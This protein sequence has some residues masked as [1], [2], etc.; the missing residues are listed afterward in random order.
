M[1]QN[2]RHAEAAAA[3][4]KTVDR[5]DPDDAPRAAVTLGTLRLES[6]DPAGAQRAFQAAKD[7]GHP[8]YAP[9]GAVLVGIRLMEAGD[10]DRAR[11]AFEQAITSHHP[12]HAPSAWVMKG[13]L[14]EKQANPA[15][16]NAAYRTAI[17]SGNPE[18][19]PLAAVGLGLLL[20]RQGDA[21]G[22]QKAYQTAIDSE[23]P[24]HAPFAMLLTGEYLTGGDLQSRERFR[25][26]AARYGN[27]D[28]LV[29]LA[30]LYIAEQ[31]V[32]TAR[33]LLQQAAV[34]GNNVAAHS[35]QL[36]GLPDT[37]TATSDAAPK[38]LLESAE[39]NDTD[40]MNMLGLLAAVHGDVLEARSWWTKSASE[41]DMI[42]P[43]LLSR[44][45]G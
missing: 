31:E 7:S 19:A 23:H 35:L 21:I 45:L 38:A 25:N 13:M 30:E 28:V 44:H 40:S 15:A 41:R 2:Q 32:P 33:R 34:L 20:Q 26:T 22:A 36:F 5:G 8:E 11:R 18:Y 4:Q 9:R 1:N 37:H 43:L 17:D 24:D 12:Q 3:L 27:P 39:E 29:S 42:A 10:W 14:L 16:A 6:G